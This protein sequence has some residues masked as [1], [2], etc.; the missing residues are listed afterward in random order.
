MTKNGYQVDCR[1]DGE[2][3][4]EY[5]CMLEVGPTGIDDELVIRE[6]EEKVLRMIPRHWFLQLVKQMHHLLR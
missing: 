5:K 6:K 4:A 2:K 1:I 3:R